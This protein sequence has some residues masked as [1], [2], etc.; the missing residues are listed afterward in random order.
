MRSRLAPL[1]VASM[2]VWLAQAGVAYQLSGPRWPAGNVV[3]HLQ[4]GASGSPLIDGSADWDTVTESAL[5]LWNASMGQ[6]SFRV[7]RNSTSG[8]ALRNNINNVVWGDDVYGEDFGD[9]VA[10]TQYLYFTSDSRMAEADVIFDRGANWNSY[11]GNQRTASGGGWLLDIRR[12]AL[13]E[14]GH[15]LGLTHPDEHG[16][17]VA[18]IMNS[19]VSN[20]D[21]LQ[22]DDVNGARALY[23]APAPPAAPANDTLDTN[24]RLTPGQSRASRNARYRLAYQAD[25]NLVLYDEVERVAVWATH[26]GGPSAGSALMQSDGNFVVYGA[27]GNGLWATNTSGHTNSRLVVQDDGNLVLYS[28]GNQP[29]WDRHRTSSP[30]PSPSPSPSPAPAPGTVSLAGSVSAQGGTRLAGVTVRILDG[31]NADRSATTDA[32]GEYRFDGL[33]SA[34]GNLSASASGYAEGRAGVFINGTNTLNFT[35]QATSTTVSE[36]LTGS[37]SSGDPACTGSSAGNKPCRRHAFTVTR[38]GTAVGRLTWSNRQNDLDLELWRGSTRV[39]SSDGV[40]TEENVSAAVSAGS[41]EWRVVYYSGST[42]QAYTLA[43]TRPN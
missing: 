11:R 18:A 24:G 42:V 30:A 10:V 28:G 8:I 33:T 34:N 5:S 3:M 37:A 41:Y 16:Q 12:V 29:I 23:G 7:V 22:A 15:V 4:Q 20:T 13:H 2:L 6:L 9:A 1:V 14:F 17:S 31:A 38:S 35:L 21:S 26:T 19:R 27:Q 25:G 39:A 36:T 32:A 40:T 43:V